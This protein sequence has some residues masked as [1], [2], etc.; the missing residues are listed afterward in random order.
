MA[1]YEVQ[2][3]LNDEQG[4]STK[5]NLLVDAVDEATAITQ[6]GLMQANLELISKCGV[7][8]AT[9]RR[10]IGFVSAPGAGSNV[11]AGSTYRWDTPLV[12]NPTTGIPDPEEATKDGQGG[13]DLG[14]VGVAAFV[15]LFVSG[16]W[17]VNRNVPT[18][19]TGVL[20]AT[21]DV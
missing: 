11:D 14:D 7:D 8:N 17:R 20:A 18:Q 9:Y 21:L 5:R 6:I 12:I 15:D 19:P 3:D 4:R 13:I 2:F 10:S 16:A 1:I